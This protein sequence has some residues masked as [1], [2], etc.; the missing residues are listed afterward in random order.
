MLRLLTCAVARQP[1]L[2]SRGGSG[3]QECDETGV[4]RVY[5]GSAGTNT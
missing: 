4:G 1:D 3:D 2:F 5:A